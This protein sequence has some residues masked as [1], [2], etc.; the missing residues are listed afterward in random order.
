MCPG[1]LLGV[2]GVGPRQINQTMWSF[3][4]GC[5]KRMERLE[6]MERME[7]MESMESMERMETYRLSL[8]SWSSVPAIFARL[9]LFK[10]IAGNLLNMQPGDTGSGSH[11][12]ALPRFVS[13]CRNRLSSSDTYD[14]GAAPHIGR[15]DSRSR[16]S[17]KGK[18]VSDLN[19]PKPTTPNSTSLARGR[20]PG[21]AP[22]SRSQ[23]LA[24][25]AWPWRV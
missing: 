19:I 22:S 8:S 12:F 23:P 25:E 10:L 21:G 9:C 13:I 5:T 6:C 20:R 11:R 16:E 7:R 14:S 3:F 17:G 2:S 24:R 18:P 15:A 4:A 1:G